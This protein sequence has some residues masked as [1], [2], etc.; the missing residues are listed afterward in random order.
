MQSSASSSDAGTTS[1]RADRMLIVNA[2][3]LYAA[4]SRRDRDHETCARLLQEHAGA[5]LIVPSLVITEVAY[6]LGDRLGPAA[7]TALARALDA[8]ELIAEAPAPSDWARI[9]ELCA[10]YEDLPLGIVDASV[11]A[12]AERLGAT[13]IATLDRRHFSAVRPEHVAAFTLLP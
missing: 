1:S 7:E 13:R 6:L 3:P 10:R 11:V 12:L 4:A 8:G 2:G 5:P 9:G